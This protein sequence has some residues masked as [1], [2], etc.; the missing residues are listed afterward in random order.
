[1]KDYF[2]TILIVVSAIVSY[3]FPKYFIEVEG[4]AL[5][6]L[7]IPLLQLIMFGMGTTMTIKDFKSVFKHPKSVF[8]GLTCQFSIMPFIGYFLTNIFKFSPEIAAGVILVGCS[9]SGLASNVMT[10]LA[11]ANVA[12]SITLTSIATLIAPI[13]TPLLMKFLGGQYIDVNF[14]SM[15]WDMI[16]MIIVPLSLGLLIHKFLKN[17]VHYF[18]AFLPYLSIFGIAALTLIV[19]AA[20]SDALKSVGI[21]LIFAM[22]LHN[23]LGFFIGYWSC[24]LFNLSEKDARTISLEVGLQNAGLASG[25]AKSMGKLATVG[26]APALFGP[27]MNTNGSIIAAL[28]GKSKIEG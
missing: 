1:M 3:H 13:M 28:W 14:W 15:M 23:L 20:S 2:F 10:Y 24:R 26:L 9:P 16:R 17:I 11:K 5:K 27:I 7:I 19:T 21:T 22:I 25:L 12:L 4:F 18:H 8:I 6:E